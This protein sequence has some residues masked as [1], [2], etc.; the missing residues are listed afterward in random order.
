MVLVVSEC[1]LNIFYLY[2]GL[3]I[4]YHMVVDDSSL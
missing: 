1:C 2:N 3:Y 4:G